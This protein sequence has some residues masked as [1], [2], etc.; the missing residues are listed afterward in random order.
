MLDDDPDVCHAII[1]AV[2]CAWCILSLTCLPSAYADHRYQGARIRAGD[3]ETNAR[4]CIG[5]AGWVDLDA[6]T[7]MVGVHARRAARHGVTIGRMARLY[8]HAL[9]HP[10][11]AW[12]PAL[13]DIRRPPAGW[14]QASWPRHRMLYRAMVE[15][16][17]EV[18]E[19]SVVDPC[20]GTMHY[21]SV[22]DGVPRGFV[23]VDC[24]DSRQRFYEREGER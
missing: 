3:V 4:A 18:L 21:G 8:S 15:H 7:A 19:G 22:A 9:R 13:R 23:R 1:A 14:P 17:R 24:V 12:V 5:E 20:P 6:C 10:R 2:I 11:R 16:V